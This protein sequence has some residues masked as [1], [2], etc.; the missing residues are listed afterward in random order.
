[1][2]PLGGRNVKYP[3]ES[4]SVHILLCGQST[5]HIYE[6][7]REFYPNHVELLTTEE[8]LQS[9]TELATELNEISNSVTVIPAFTSSSI[10]ESISIILQ[11]YYELRNRYPLAKFY[12]GITGGTNTMVT[13]VAYAALI[14]DVELHYI[15]KLSEPEGLLDRFI[16]FKPGEIF[17]R[18]NRSANMGGDLK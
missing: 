6:V 13:S 16:F 17:A 2:M 5:G 12:F 15:I 10:C 14:V 11:K 8:L 7:I 18:F 4:P 3:L 1:M 9:T